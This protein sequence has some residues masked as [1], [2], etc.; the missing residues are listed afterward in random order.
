MGGADKTSSSASRQALSR[1]Y[2]LRDLLPEPVPPGAYFANFDKTLESWPGKK[3]CFLEIECDLQ[4]L[5]AEAWAFLKH[6]LAPLLSARHPTRGWQQLFDKLNQA[7]AYRYL[8]QRGFSSI[9][10]IAESNIKG[11]LT[12]DIRATDSDRTVL[13]EVKTLNISDVEAN[14]R[15]AGAVGT[16]TDRLNDQFIGKLRSTIGQATRQMRVYADDKQ[17]LYIAYIIINFDDTLHEYADRYAAQL[18]AFRPTFSDGDV[19]IV[20]SYKGP[21]GTI[22]KNN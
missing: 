10:F 1:V 7:K 8:R 17:T 9:R 18:E 19:E 15:H 11:S 2:E 6:E 3:A 5:D 21:F 12:P 20:L 4:S 16:S 22:L 13:C 14:R